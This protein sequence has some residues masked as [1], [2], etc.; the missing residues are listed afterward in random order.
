ME[1]G[2]RWKLERWIESVDG[3]DEEKYLLSPATLTFL[4][5]VSR[6]SFI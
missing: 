3:L 2:H 1:W 5:P 6:K 4:V